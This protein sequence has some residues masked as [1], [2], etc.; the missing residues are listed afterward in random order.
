VTPV[1]LSQLAE[2]TGG[3]LTGADCVI[4]GYS[5]D[6]RTV[7]AG[8]VYFCLRGDNFDGHDFAQDAVDKG[9]VAVVCE[10]A[11]DIDVTQLVVADSRGA[12]GLYAMLWRQQFSHPVIGVTGSNGK[13]TVKQLLAGIFS[14][15]GNTHFTR[16]NDNNEIGVPQ[17]LLG[18]NARHEFAVVEM[19]ASEKGEIERLGKLVRPT[20]SVITNAGAA[21]LEGFGDAQSVADEKA[22]IYRSL[23]EGGNAVINAD[24]EFFGYWSD[25]CANKNIITFGDAGDVTAQRIDD[26]SISITHNG[27]SVNCEYQLAGLHNVQ[28][29]AAA[30]ACAIAAGLPFDLIA[31][32]LAEAVPVAGRLNFIDLVSGITVIDDTYNANPASTRAAINVLSEFDG[33]RFMVLGDLLELGVDE[34]EQHKDVGK[35]ARENKVDRLL[36]FGELSKHTATEFGAGAESFQSKEDLINTLSNGLTENSTVL[37]KGSRSMK[38]EQVVEALKER[39]EFTVAEGEVCCQ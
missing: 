1:S 16:A 2:A 27:K 3:R 25:V 20:V 15:A 39:F 28:N 21:H 17:T 8:D 22:W 6:T 36:T 12:F 35:Y 32:G 11:Q 38:M 18:L 26:G 24:S 14:Q 37:V 5:T 9:A 19:G 31:K 33:V 10:S 29:A 23:A 34:V 30:A 4:T 7:S 13:T